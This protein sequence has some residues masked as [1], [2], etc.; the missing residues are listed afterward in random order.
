M[1]DVFSSIRP[2]IALLIALIGISLSTPATAD[3]AAAERAFEEGKALMDKRDYKRACPKLEESLALEEAV[4]ARFMLG[5]CYEAAGKV[6]SAWRNYQRAANEAAALGQGERAE[7]AQRRAAETK[8]KVPIVTLVVV[9]QVRALSGVQFL[10]N[11]QPLDL[12]VAERGMPVDPG[13]HRFEVRAARHRSW[14]RVF[15][16]RPNGEKIR[17]EVS[18]LSALGEGEPDSMPAPGSPPPR[19]APTSRDGGPG[20]LAIAGFVVAG[21]G[22]VGMGIGVGI[23][24]AAKSDYDTALETHCVQTMCPPAGVQ[25]TEDARG[26]GDVASVLFGVSAG[27]TAT[28]VLLAVLGLVGVGEEVAGVRIDP[29]ADGVRLGFGGSF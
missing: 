16:V 28:G 8:A 19:P 26:Q 24:A 17:L 13:E 10:H 9:P 2:L 21:A 20:A 23:A 22:L 4:G 15:E 5:E 3:S 7:Y 27:V 1:N 18:E 11:G 29:T 12:A 14:V 6:A 25:A